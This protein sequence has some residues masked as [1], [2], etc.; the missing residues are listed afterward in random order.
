MRTGRIV[1]KLVNDIDSTLESDDAIDLLNNMNLAE[2]LNLGR[3]L[4]EGVYTRYYPEDMAVVHVL[5]SVNHEVNSGSRS[6]VESDI[7]IAKF[8][9]TDSLDLLQAAEKTWNL[10]EQLAQAHYEEASNN[11]LQKP[12]VKKP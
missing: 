9:R 5:V 11:P 1:K 12:E 7:T 6:M 3:K 10:T 2:V 4:G 8:D